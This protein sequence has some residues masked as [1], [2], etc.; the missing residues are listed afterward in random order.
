[1]FRYNTTVV[2]TQ[3]NSINLDLVMV[4]YTR[5]QAIA[6][7]LDIRIRTLSRLWLC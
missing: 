4:P 1:M 7:T 3:E 2:T 6:E 5:I